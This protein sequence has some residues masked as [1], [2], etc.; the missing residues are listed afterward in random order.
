MSRQ[1]E[2]SYP[3]TLR[4]CFFLVQS[5]GTGL[6]F[7]VAFSICFN[8]CFCSFNSLQS[9]KKKLNA[10]MISMSLSGQKR[11]A[12]HKFD[13]DDAVIITF[14]HD[15]QAKG[16]AYANIRHELYPGEQPTAIKD[17]A[18]CVFWNHLKEYVLEC[19]INSTLCNY[20]GFKFKYKK[21]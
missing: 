15:R 18:V 6:I 11:E 20:T 19:P 1:L 5:P 2:H 3:W 4:R 7:V 12:I 17:T 14:K 21:Y 9:K 13:S 10:G 16:P 8:Y